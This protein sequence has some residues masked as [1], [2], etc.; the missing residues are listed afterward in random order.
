MKQFLPLLCAITSFIS[1]AYAGPERYSNKDM[2]A[3]PPCP[4]YADREWNASLWGTYAFMSAD[5]PTL[6]NSVEEAIGPK[7]PVGPGSTFPEHDTYLEADHAWGAGLTRS[8]S[9]AATSESD[10]RAMPS[11]FARATRMYLFLFLA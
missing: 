1:A 7:I 6:Q 3:S 4:W 8:I 11:T 5:Y 2:A 9:F 10:S